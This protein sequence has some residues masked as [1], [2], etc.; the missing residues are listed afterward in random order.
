M[1]DSRQ[2]DG[3]ETRSEMQRI[4]HLLGV[5]IIWVSISTFQSG[6]TYADAAV[7]QE[8]SRCGL[9]TSA[10]PGEDQIEPS[11]QVTAAPE[12][13][14]DLVF[15][16]RMIGHQAG[17]IALA[18]VALQNAQVS[19]VRRIALRIVESQAGEIQLLRSWR[20]SW[21]FG[22]E[23]SNPPTE[24][25]IDAEPAAIALLCSAADF[26]RTFLVLM[27][28]HH[29][30]AIELAK[31]GEQRAQHEDLR[32]F[33]GSIVEIQSDEV[34]SMQVTLERLTTPVPAS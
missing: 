33:A 8:P 32:K 5:A 1:P 21:Y 28:A 34:A 18:N 3:L 26:D 23:N 25:K 4:R 30:T 15:I 20:D 11:L 24:Q 19:E 9:A 22:Y 13:P 31:K 27:I 12:A 16:D 2:G 29:E 14:F 7:T 6:I 10:L 17:A